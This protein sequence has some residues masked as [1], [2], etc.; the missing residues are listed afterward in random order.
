MS[1]ELVFGREPGSVFTLHL[2]APKPVT[3]EYS[4]SNFHGMAF[5]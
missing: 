4:I 5:G 1:N 3:I 2:E